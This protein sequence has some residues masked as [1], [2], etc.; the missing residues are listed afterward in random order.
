MKQTIIITESQYNRLLENCE[1]EE[2]ILGYHGSPCSTIVT[3][4]FKKGKIGYM[5]PGIYFGATKDYVRHYAKKFGNG[6]IYTVNITMY[7]PLRLTSREPTEELLTTIYGTPSVYRRRVAKQS[8]DTYNVTSKD[9]KK[10]LSQG[11][12]GVIWQWSDYV[13]YVVYD[14]KQIEILDKEEV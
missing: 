10:L 7:N 3:G 2:E 6:T 14:P 9:I 1:T 12:D 5:G 13:E 8:L 4:K 11:Y